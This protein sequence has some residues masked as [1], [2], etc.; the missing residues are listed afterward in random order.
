MNR[1]RATFETLQ[2]GARYGLAALAVLL[3]LVAYV[4][5]IDAFGRERSRLQGSVTALRA[6]S[7]QME[8]HA[9]EIAR[10]RAAPKPAAS[11]RDLR[12]VIETE[13]K[14]GGFTHVLRVDSNAADEVRVI[15]AS[16]AYP[17]WLAWLERLQ[18]ADVRVKSCRVEA[19]S[20]EG[21]VTATATFVRTP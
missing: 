1:V 8:R 15:V 5:V 10:L 14:A 4:A 11:Q 18:S 2:P 6:A 20:T 9:V 12:S 7:Q 19:L 16:I 13:A 3:T 21:A 17:E